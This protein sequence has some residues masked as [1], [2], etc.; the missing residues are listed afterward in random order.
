MKLRN[1]LISNLGLASWLVMGTAV[2]S[3]CSA[4]DTVSTVHKGTTGGSSGGSTAG[5][6]GS[7]GSIDTGGGGTSTT[8][9]G[10]SGVPN[11]G[12]ANPATGG[13]AG[14]AIVM[15]P[16]ASSTGGTDASDATPVVTCDDAAMCIKAALIH[17]YSFNGTGTTAS[18]TVGTAHG[19]VVNGTLSGNGD[20]VF[21]GGDSAPATYVDLPNGIVG[22]LTNATFEV[23]LTWSGG[24]N[25]QRIF[26]FG[27][28]TGAEN[29]QGSAATT[30]YLTPQAGGPTVMLAAFKRAD[31]TYDVETRA[32]STNALMTGA[33]THVAVVVDNAHTLMTLYRN[34]IP[35][36]SALLTDTFS[37]ISD[38]NNWLGRSQYGGDAGFVGTL[39]E[40]RIYNA[41]LPP[42]VILASFTAGP[43][44]TF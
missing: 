20:V 4:E 44:A 25:W 26:D 17:R 23:W 39:H 35:D 32:Q 43:T 28:S 24:G 3:A 33:M 12:S 7:A 16:D 13:A 9:I 34:G 22:T 19:T 15:L 8:G 18:D 31:Q 2:T 14:D 21:A 36:G 38:V 42:D 41:A 5:A 40:F 29:T 6:G 27:S 1:A 11:G 30:F 37:A 10:G